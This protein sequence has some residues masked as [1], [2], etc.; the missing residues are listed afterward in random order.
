MDTSAGG[1]C[2]RLHPCWKMCRAVLI[3][4]GSI[5]A[6]SQIHSTKQGGK[7]NPR[8]RIS[9]EDTKLLSALGRGLSCGSWWLEQPFPQIDMEPQANKGLPQKDT[10]GS[11]R[12]VVLALPVL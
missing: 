9:A 1:S 2:W 4:G 12:E 6:L 7:L 11:R 5:R 8:D 10:V 3:M